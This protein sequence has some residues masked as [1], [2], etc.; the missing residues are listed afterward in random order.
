VVVAGIAAGLA[1]SG[2]NDD[3]LAG[4]DL[5]ISET[6]DSTEAAVAL[7][8]QATIQSDAV[9]IAVTNISAGA[10]QTSAAISFITPTL[11]TRTAV[12]PSTINVGSATETTEPSAT[13]V[14]P[15][16]T[17]TPPTPTN[18]PTPTVTDTPTMTYTPTL[19]P[20]PSLPPNGLQGWQ[21]LV[22]LFP[23]IENLPW[24]VEEFAP[25]TGNAGWRLGVGSQTPGDEIQ[26]GLEPDTLDLY[27]GNDAPSRIR[28][29][30]ATLS[31]TTFD[32]TLLDS[33][34]VYFVILLESVDD[35]TMIAGLY[36]QVVNLNVVN[37]WQIQGDERTFISQRS[38]NAVIARVRLERDPVSG[39]VLM[40]FNDTQVGSAVPFVPPEAPV[41]PR[42]FVKDGGV[43]VGVT[44]WRINL[45]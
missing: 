41:Q 22:T 10:T 33:D 37:L 18:T 31:L 14:T 38:V 39:N 45:G 35:P 36:I 17:P 34:D 11:I 20:T 12:T 16:D 19:S 13:P 21:D 9:G 5:I 25:A 28:R 29:T 3:P 15:S 40:L 26:V 6:P 23:R 4:I 32:P 44:S 7:L 1:L 2:G 30:D 43:I 42:L 27:F 8:T 24:T